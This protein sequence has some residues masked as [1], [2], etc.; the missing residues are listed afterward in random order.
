MCVDNFILYNL[1]YIITLYI[2]NELL[3]ILM[4]FK[5]NNKITAQN[6]MIINNHNNMYIV[7]SVR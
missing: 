1:F 5:L 6:D 3:Y 4:I 2:L 7:N